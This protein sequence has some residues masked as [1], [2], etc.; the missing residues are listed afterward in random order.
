[1]SNDE[2]I[3]MLKETFTEGKLKE[4]EISMSETV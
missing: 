3:N 1:M 4:T 2:A